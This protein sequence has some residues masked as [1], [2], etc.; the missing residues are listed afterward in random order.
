M[1]DEAKAKIEK[2][3]QI[4]KENL[5]VETDITEGVKK[6]DIEIMDAVGKNYFHVKDID[7]QLFSL[8]LKHLANGVYF[9]K[10]IQGRDISVFKIIK[11]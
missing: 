6:Y 10:V 1:T 5:V 4:L 3:L 7:N 2:A 9:A 11:N 8:D